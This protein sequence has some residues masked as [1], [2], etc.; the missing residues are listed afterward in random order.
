MANITNYLNKIKTAV[1]GKDVRGAIHDAIKQVY[2]DAS[3]NHDNAN[4]EVKLARGTHTTLND[5]LDKSDEIQAQTN[6]QLSKKLDKN[7][8]LSMANMGQDVKEAMTGGS[9][10]VVGVDAILTENIVN[11]QVTPLKTNFVRNSTNLVDKRFLSKDKYVDANG[12]IVDFEGYYTTDFIEVQ[13]NIDYTFSNPRTIC[14]FDENFAKVSFTNNSTNAEITKNTPVKATYVRCS[15]KLEYL[16]SFKIEIGSQLTAYETGG[17]KSE[18]LII[19]FSNLSDEIINSINSNNMLRNKLKNK[20]LLNLGDS[21][22]FGSGNNGVGYAEIIANKYD[23]IYH[24][25]SN[26]GA[27]IGMTEDNNILTQLDNA[28]ASGVVPD[29]V[30]FDGGTNDISPSYNVPLGAISDDYQGITYDTTTFCGGLEQILKKIRNTWINTKIIYVRV[31]NMASRDVA[32]QKLYG[33]KALE[34]CEKWSV[35][36]VD[37]FKNGQLNTNINVMLAFTNNND[38]THPN[39]LGYDMFYIPLIENKLNSI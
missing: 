8:V 39:R 17:L 16:D 18:K 25:Y 24:D 2:D 5:R 1:Y 23:M 20:I 22:A 11:G 6:A 7:S 27:T 15:F 37:L 33:E 31:H 32:L 38:K 12:E 3:V 29:Y 36:V 34:I 14:Y 26:G 9:V 21:I 4:M 28:I 19:E 13:K 35:P 10:A 30:I